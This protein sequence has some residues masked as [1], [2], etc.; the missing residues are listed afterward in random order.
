MGVPFD[1]AVSSFRGAAEAPARLRKLS[2]MTPPVSEEGIDLRGLV[3]HDR[4]DLQVDPEGSSY[5]DTVR[6]EALE[7]IKKGK[8][9]LFFGGDHSITIPLAG[10]FAEHYYPEPVG[11]IHIDSHCD[12]MERYEGVQWSHACPQRR[13]LEQ[14]NAA[15]ENL[16]LV[17]IRNL[18]VEEMEF[19]Q[20]HPSITMITS[21]QFYHR[22]R[23]D[24]VEQVIKAMKGV[25]A[26]YLSLDIDVLDPAYAPGTGVP[27]AGG[28]TTREVI[29][30]VREMILSLPV[31]AMDLVE[32]APPLD[33]SDITSWSA[34]KI[35]YE[36]FAALVSSE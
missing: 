1:G 20:E 35:I 28:L 8:F 21:R 19:L 33:H 31:K 3:I 23:T 11:M 4:G 17:G 9:T 6:E 14:E 12:L 30:F 24:I 2:A 26:V 16:A 32:V 10:A 5:F 15:A 22:P 18:E 25:E 27:E 34:V 29:E 36:T 13:F 7:L